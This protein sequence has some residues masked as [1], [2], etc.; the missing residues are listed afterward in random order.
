V[1]EAA[2]TAEMAPLIIAAYELSDRELEITQLVA[3]GLATGEIAERLFI[4]PHTVRDH[5]K[6]VFDKTRVSSRGEL[7][8]KLFTEHYEP[9]SASNVVRVRD[10]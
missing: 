1:I 9:S 6:V 7:V 10:R 2:R 5:I 8:A 3:R 4:S